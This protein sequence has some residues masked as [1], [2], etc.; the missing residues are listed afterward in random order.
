MEEGIS[1]L[2]V[3]FRDDRA[4][5]FPGTSW[6]CH[7][8]APINCRLLFTAKCQSRRSHRLSDRRLPRAPSLSSAPSPIGSSDRL[9]DRPRQR[10]Q[11]VYSTHPRPPES[12]PSP[13]PLWKTRDTVSWGFSPLDG[14]FSLPQSRSILVSQYGQMFYASMNMCTVRL[15]SLNVT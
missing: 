9:T 5:P 8:A 2:P 7:G 13:L 4:S 3:D 14:A 15:Y 11:S 10:R 1:D 12:L 6:R